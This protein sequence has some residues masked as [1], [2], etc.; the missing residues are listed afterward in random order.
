MALADNAVVYPNTAHI[1]LGTSDSAAKPTLAQLATFI[2]DTSAPPT[3]FVDLGHTTQDNV[4]AWGSDGGDTAVKGSLQNRALKQIVTSEAI[5][6]FTVAAM[7]LKDNAVLSLYF[8]G[9]DVSVADTFSTPD[10]PTVTNK[11]VLVVISTDDGPFGVYAKKAGITRDDSLQ[12]PAD[13]FA[14]APLRFTPLKVTGSPK[15][16]F[17]AAGLGT[18]TP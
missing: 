18:A 8:G 15:M 17:I 10:S 5:D 11:P 12:M 14:S 6:Y 13:D 4:L 16:Q 3:G 7:Q 2:A 1:L 9:G